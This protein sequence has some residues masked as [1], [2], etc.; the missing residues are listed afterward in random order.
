L[1][2]SGERGLKDLRARN[3]RAGGG[4]VFV[5]QDASLDIAQQSRQARGSFVSAV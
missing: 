3:G 5:E 4:D 1:G 2:L